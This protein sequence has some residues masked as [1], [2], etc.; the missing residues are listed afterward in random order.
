M[1]R[2]PTDGQGDDMAA[3]IGVVHKDEAS[4]YSV[5][6]PDFP[7]CVTA[8]KTLDEAARFAHEALALHLAGLAEDG[9]GIPAAAPLRRVAGDPENA[10]AVAF[11][12]VTAD[13]PAGVRRAERIN[14]TLD[15]ALLARID[16]EARRR[17]MKRSTFLAEGARR[18]LAE[19]AA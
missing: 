9:E 4:D 11:L 19:R 5:S 17:G 2:Q 3:Y 1:R 14:V 18:L 16:A 6:F 7:G 15:A 8:G 10:E 13:V 12:A